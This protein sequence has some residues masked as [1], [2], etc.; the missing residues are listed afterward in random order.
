M[1]EDRVCFKAILPDTQSIHAEQLMAEIN[2]NQ[3]RAMPYLKEK[4]K[5]ESNLFILL[6]TNFSS[7]TFRPRFSSTNEEL[8][9]ENSHLSQSLQR[10]HLHHAAIH[11]PTVINQGSPP[12]KAPIPVQRMSDT[13]DINLSFSTAIAT[14]TSKSSQ[15][16]GDGGSE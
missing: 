10:R 4:K 7:S 16:P 5:K 2:I 15:T 1:A 13:A 14:N 6:I 11:Y 12:P 8:N 9:P 3:Q